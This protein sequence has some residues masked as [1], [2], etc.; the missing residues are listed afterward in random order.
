LGVADVGRHDHP[1]FFGNFKVIVCASRSSAQPEALIAVAAGRIGREL[2]VIKGKF[3]L[4]FFFA[5]R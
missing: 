1:R 3:A 2:Y 4:P 5:N